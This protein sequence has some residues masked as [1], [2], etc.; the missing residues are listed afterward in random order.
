MNRERDTLLIV[1]DQE[2]NRALLKEAFQSDYRVLEAEN[3][4]EACLLLTEEKNQICAIL[5]DLYMPVMDGFGVLTYLQ[6]SGL[7][8]FIPVFIIT[9]A[10]D[11]ETLMKGYNMG[12][13]DIVSKPVNIAFTRRR[14]GNAIEL[15]QH[16]NQLQYT[17]RAQTEEIMKQERVILETQR[18]IMETLSTAIEFRDAES[19]EHVSRMRFITRELLNSIQDRWTEYGLTEK[20]IGMMSDAAVV[21]DVGKIMVPD[22]ILRKPGEL[23]PE[24][25]EIM[26]QHTVNGCLILDKIPGIQDS[27]YLKYC[28]EICRWHHERWDG[29]GY[30]D[31]LAGD[32]IPIHAQA[33]SLADVY[34]ALASR[35]VYHPAYPHE[36]VMAMILGGECGCFNPKLL[37]CLR[38][39]APALQERYRGET[40][41]ENQPE[42]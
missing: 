24:E 21:H 7:L 30:P 26:K 16:R 17:V 25:F 40:D 4:R 28:Y 13:M 27:E 14:L 8:E 34:D 1:D 2:V 19:G 33:V 42:A 38:R 39:V 11:S 31:G 9:A 6:E 22:A 20:R 29:A 37:E 23:T 18:S 41:G 12:A 5:L 10:G 3:G 15:Y 32:R 36:R 35:R